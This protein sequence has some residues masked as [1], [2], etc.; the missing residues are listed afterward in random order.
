LI[1]LRAPRFSGQVTDVD[2][3]TVAVSGD[4]VATVDGRRVTVPFTIP[5]ERVRIRLDGTLRS[6]AIRVGCRTRELMATLIVSSDRG[7]RV[8]AATRRVLE[9]MP[10]TSMHLNV[11]ARDDAFIFGPSTRHLHGSVRM[12]EEVAQ[13]R[14]S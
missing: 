1:H 3:D 4:G 10:P 9:R 8:R 14:R 11:H 5:G 2:I 6:L 12:R 13:E 7:R